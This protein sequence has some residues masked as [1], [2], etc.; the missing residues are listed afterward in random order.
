[1]NKIKIETEY[2]KL[3]QL[4]KWAGIAGSGTDAKYFISEG[5]VSINGEVANQ[6]GKKVY[7]GDSVKVVLEEIIEFSV[8]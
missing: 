7:P 4:L 1:M 6:R 8:E 2:I 5:F 3:D